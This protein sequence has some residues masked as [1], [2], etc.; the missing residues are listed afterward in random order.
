MEPDD[1]EEVNVVHNGVMMKKN[2]RDRLYYNSYAAS[3][4]KL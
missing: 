3:S 2:I 4:F 1:K